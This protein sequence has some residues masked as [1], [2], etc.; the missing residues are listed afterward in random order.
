MRS[1][2]S[3]ASLPEPSRAD[4]P[5][6][7]E[8]PIAERVMRA[9][10]AQIIRNGAVEHEDVSAAADRLERAGDVEAAHELRCIVLDAITSDPA[11]WNAQAARSRFRAL[12]GGKSED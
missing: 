3:Q 8:I 11:D 2:A 6:G 7:M 1:M 4:T 9:F 12:D 10:I 5:D